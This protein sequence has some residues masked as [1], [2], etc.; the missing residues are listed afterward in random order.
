MILDPKERI[1]EYTK[2]GWYGNKTLI[3]YFEENVARSPDSEALVDAPNREQLDGEKPKRLT[4]SQLG[5]AV[6]RLALHMLEMGVKKDDIV[7][8]Q[9]P[10]VVELAI[11]YLAIGRIGAITTPLAV[12]Y[13]RHELRYTMGVTEP[14]AF[15]TTTNFK[16]FNY[17]EMVQDIAPE[18][19]SLKHIIAV[20]KNVPEGVSSF[21]EMVESNIEE[22]YPADYLD[23]YK[24][25]ANEIFTICWTSGTTADPKGCPR[26]H[27]N[28]ICHARA[29]TDGVP[30][31]MGATILLPYPLVNLASLTVLYVP[32]LMTGGKLALHHPFDPQVFVQ[33]LNEENVNWVGTA[34]AMLNALIQLGLLPKANLTSE[35]KIGSGAAP[36]SEWMI[37]EFAKY[38]VDIINYYGSNEGAGLFSTPQDVPDPA[39][40]AYLFPRW[41]APG[42]TWHNKAAEMYLTKLVDPTTGEVITERG[43]AGELCVKGPTVFP[44]Y[45]KRPDLTQEAF[46]SEG[47]FRTGDLFCIEGENLDRYKFVG[48]LKDLIIR[49]GQ[50]I[51]PEEIEILVQGH[52]K[53]ADVAAIGMPDRRLGEKVCI[54]V[55]PKPGE[56]VT[57]E[58]I[59]DYL[60]EKDVAVFK[61]PE[62]MEIIDNLPRNPVGKIVKNVLREDIKK[63]LDEQ[64]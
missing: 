14:V 18:F 31:K 20:G 12:Q 58:E 44:G 53:V 56:S 59:I 19:P 35:L 5:K 54:Y 62:R 45:Y 26:S 43:K 11:S 24:P 61:L 51:S 55:V 46:D 8:V 63:K 57:L 41:G 30:L 37:E 38:G 1:E 48:R 2:K 34:P 13:R 17:V 4:W 16:Q 50:N 29:V 39:E 28:W 23:K 21:E 47:Y 60:K 22:K 27:N 25:E 6:D 42:F 40:R 36:L 52:P 15:I 33:Q 32:W 64:T 49:G 10:N 9:L 3:D 7:M